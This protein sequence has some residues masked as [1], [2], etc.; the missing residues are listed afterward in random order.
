MNANQ[1]K[2]TLATLGIS[3][4]DLG[5][6]MLDVEPLTEVHDLIPD[7]ALYVA[8][9]PAMWWVNG[10][11]QKSHLTLLYGLLQPGPVWREQID[12][13]ME[14][15][16]PTGGL[17]IERWTA[18]EPPSAEHDYACIVGEV[19]RSKEIL[20]AHARLSFL[21]HINTYPEY[22]PHVT[23]A[24]VKSE[25]KDRVLT[26]LNWRALDDDLVPIGLNYGGERA[27]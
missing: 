17:Y 26:Y 7:E 15:W 12:A 25:W 11:V 5:C 22:K 10:R 16:E 4:P 19:H 9:D 8:D 14:G 21:P 1:Y 18:F 27:V 13:V 24:Y 20:E 2:D 6:V 3:I 23:V